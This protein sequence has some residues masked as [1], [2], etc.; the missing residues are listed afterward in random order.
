MSGTGLWQ[1]YAIAAATGG[2]LHGGGE[3]RADGISIDSRSIRPGDLFFALK[4]ERDGHD[5]APDALARGA[6]AAVVTRPLDVRG[7]QLVVADTQRALEALAEAARDRFFGKLIGVTGSAGK[8]TTKEMLRAALAP[9]GE[10]HAAVKSFNNHIGVPMTL[11]ELPPSAAAGVV[12]MG[13]N[14]AQEIRGLTTLVRPHIALITTIAEAH[15]ENLGSLEA[16]ADAKAEIAEGLRPGGAMILPADSPYL[17]RLEMRCAEVGVTAPLTFGRNGREARLVDVEP[18]GDGQVIA[19]DVLGTDVRFR[20]SAAG[21]HMAGN[22]IAALLAACLA[23]CAPADAAAALEAFRSA[24]GRGQ[25]LAVRIRGKTISIL[26][27]SYNANPASMRA[28]FSVLAASSGRKIAVLGDMK[29][30]GPASAEL[31]KGLARDAAGAADR[32]HTA[33]EDMAHLRA[34]LPAGRRGHHAE[35]AIDLVDALLAELEEGDT[36]LF[37][38]SN[39]S[40]VGEL[41]RALLEVGERV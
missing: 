8:T 5:F 19:G 25:R 17:G 13:M 11:A 10:I 1:A 29:E 28:A 23:G 41:V 27:E 33:G 37:K 32:I 30:L 40:R 38:G 24:E 7:P 9:M 6:A 4:A 2:A 18:D 34:A 15:L 39:A 14:H 35:K 3:W 12:E 16:I 22:A 20:L 26:D 36:V 21:E 31:H